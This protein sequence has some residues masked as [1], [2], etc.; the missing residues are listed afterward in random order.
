[1]ASAR[2]REAL[3][4]WRGEP[5]SDLPYEAVPRHEIAKLEELHLGAVEDRIE[6]D[7]HLGASCATRGRAPDAR[8]RASAARTTR[9]AADARPVPVGA[10]GRGPRGLSRDPGGPEQGARDRPQLVPPATGTGVL[11]QD[12]GLDWRP[13]P[14][15]PTATEPSPPPSSRVVLGAIVGVLA[16]ALAA[17][18]L[19]AISRDEPSLPSSIAPG[20][21]DAL[22]SELKA[23]IPTAGVGAGAPAWADGSLWVANTISGTVARIDPDRTRCHRACRPTGLRPISRRVRARCGC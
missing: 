16:A 22:T 6:A 13:P 21:I 9:R 19:I 12:P 11:H 15:E 18:S 5:M 10:P 17:I 3:E 23:S 2:L 7:L 4:L 20:R 1:M 14:S 8:A